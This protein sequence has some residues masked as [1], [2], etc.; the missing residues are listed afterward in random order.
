MS[1]EIYRLCSAVLVTS[2]VSLAWGSSGC[3]GRLDLGNPEL[4]AGPGGDP[5]SPSSHA[6]SGSQ[7]SGDGSVR[8][9]T[10]S[11]GASSDARL[12]QQ[13]PTGVAGTCS[14]GGLPAASCAAAGDYCGIAA[15]ASEICFFDGMS[16]GVC[17]AEP[18]AGTGSTWT[19]LYNDYFGGHGRAACAGNGTCHGSSSQPGAGYSNYVCPP[20]GD[21]GKE[22]CYETIVGSGVASQ[23]VTSVLRSVSCPGCLM[24]LAPTQIYTF[25]QTDLDRISAWIDAG[26]PNN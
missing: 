21:A 6:D 8:A 24:P 20:D 12:A 14:D 19:E 18:E 11:G 7:E 22:T 26:M 3:D 1:F 15:P 10:D 4:A 16:S 13:N 2:L 25:S 23:L 9:R 5:G 17:A